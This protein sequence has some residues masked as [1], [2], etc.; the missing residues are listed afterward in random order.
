MGLNAEFGYCKKFPGWFVF[1]EHFS[2]E[3]GPFNRWKRLSG[4]L[5]GWKMRE[6]RLI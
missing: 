1:L 3:I 4:R 6:Y 2:G 5:F